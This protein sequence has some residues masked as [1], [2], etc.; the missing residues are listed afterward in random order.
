[1]S[2][3]CMDRQR[4][5]VSLVS[6]RHAIRLRWYLFVVDSIVIH[7]SDKVNLSLVASNNA[8]VWAKDVFDD[9]LA[10]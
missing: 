7:R 9:M 10:D 5:L 3:D 6:W 1:M 4:K 2:L 8:E